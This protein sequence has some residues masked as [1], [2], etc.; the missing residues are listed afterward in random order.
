MFNGYKI[1]NQ[2]FTLQYLRAFSVDGC[3]K[4]LTGSE[5]CQLVSHVKAQKRIHFLT[6]VQLRIAGISV[7]NWP[8]FSKI[9]TS[10]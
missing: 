3:G 10:Y 9:M 7:F 1:N 4:A 2:N 6:T 8:S 5:S